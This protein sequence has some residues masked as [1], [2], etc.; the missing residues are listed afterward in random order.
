MFS[1]LQLVRRLGRQRLISA[2]VI[3]G[4]ALSVALGVAVP[5]A[6]DALAALG[7]RAT[8]EALPPP[9]R[10]IQFLRESSPFDAEVRQTIE[11]QLGDLLG[12]RYLMSY[13]SLLA[14][15]RESPPLAGTVR[16]RTQGGLAEHIEIRRGSPSATAQSLPENCAASPLVAP[17]EVLISAEQLQPGSFAVGDQLCIGETLPA[18]IAGSFVAKDPQAAYWF[19]DLRPIRGE[20]PSGP[21]ASELIPVLMLDQDSFNTAAGQF[22]GA[23][24]AHAYRSLARDSAI[25]LDSMDR[26][27][28]S[29]GTLRAELAALQ[30]HPILVQSGLDGAVATFTTRFRLLQSALIAL[31]LLLVVLAMIYIVLV[32]V[33]VAQQQ[34][35][36]LALLAS[37]GAGRRQI[38]LTQIGQCLV[39]AVPGT[40][41]GVALGTLG[42]LAL[43][44][45]ALF[46]RLGGGGLQLRVTPAMLILPALILLVAVLGLVLAGRPALDNTQVTLRQA[47][48]RPSRPGWMRTPLDFLLLV[49]AA[50]GVWQLRRQGGSLITTPDGSVQLNLISLATPT[51]L[52]IAGA[53]L[54]LRL[55]PAAVRVLGWSLARRRGL[56]ATLS[57]WQLARNPLVYGRLALLLTLT[58]ALGVYS[59]TVISTVIRAQQGLALDQAGADV[60]IPLQP[61]DDPAAI[62]AGL[63]AAADTTISRVDAELLV[64]RDG[65]AYRQGS[66]SLLGV[67]G[68]ALGDVLERSGSEDRALLQALR[69]I[70]AVPAS[71]LGLALPPGADTIELQVQGDMG[72]V[73]VVVKLAGLNGEREV[74]LGEPQTAWQRLEAAIPPDLQAPLTLQ[75]VIVAATAGSA[76]GERLVVDQLAARAGTTRTVLHDFEQLDG[77]E[78]LGS[79]AGAQPRLEP[80]P[81]FESGQAAQLSLGVLPAGDWAALSF[82]V[83]AGIPVFTAYGAG[84]SRANLDQPVLLRIG[85]LEFEAAVE[86][87][88]GRFPGADDQQTV[89]VADRARLAAL[90]GY[91]RP[92]G[93]G[94]V[95]LENGLA[96]PPPAVEL[97]IALQPG[98]EARAGQNGV[99]KAAGLLALAA[100]PLSNGLQ[101]ILLLGFGCGVILSIFGL[102]T[103]SALTIQARRIEWAVLGALGVSSR[104][105]LMLIAFELGFVL[106][107]SMLAGTA[108]GLLL[109]AATQPF[110]QIVVPGVVRLPAGVA[111]Q[112]YLPL[113]GGLGLALAAT[114]VLLLI[115]VQRRGM[116]RE[117]RLGEG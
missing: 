17:V 19:E 109:S 105:I 98:V 73:A 99:T 56:V 6:T 20:T 50:F 74:L 84:G 32:G 10:H 64:Q 37:R 85:S 29:F 2:S 75:S 88:L 114:L 5:L 106:A 12:E 52:L 87:R 31:L 30:P 49:F 86:Q 62:A 65:V 42:V 92:T 41:L 71:P 14:A 3:I 90:L 4:I 43:S 101:V 39:L 18:V 67:D 15:R 1:V 13:L 45:S 113:A 28:A 47:W 34:N 53:L 112:S 33:L 21:G 70:D 103:Y 40:I 35:T 72:Q 110:L 48:A 27:A 102:L 59:Q 91:G 7:L 38:L 22:P 51:I 108:I 9:N 55:F 96:M 11:Q 89:L 46:Q 116:I 8:V 16:L 81:G 78:A 69:R 44:R 95:E 54:F 104:Q 107:G 93:E 79:G 63:P 23:Q 77:W 97:R 83:P 115:S 61:D 58:I 26:L 80:A 57:A 100:D 25:S 24:A 82:R 94:P 117:L 36:E 66:I 60:R 111:W 76:G 68:A